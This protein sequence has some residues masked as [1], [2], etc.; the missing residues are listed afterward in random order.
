M[1]TRQTVVTDSAD[2]DDR[3]VHSSDSNSSW[4]IALV[5]LAV[6]F[7]LFLLFRGSFGNNNDTT[8][9][10]PTNVENNTQT[11]NNTSPTSNET[12]NP[13]TTETTPPA[14][15]TQPAQ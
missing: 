5:V 15:T 9:P 8:T 11:E 12:T 2:A 6:L 13:D 3:V 14:D 4:V 1:A 10:A 7:V